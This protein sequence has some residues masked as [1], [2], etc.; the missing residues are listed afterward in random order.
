[1]AI[2]RTNQEWQTLFNQYESSNMTQR[3]FCE[4]SP[5]MQN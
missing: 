4:L 2:R 5:I 1:M 3:A